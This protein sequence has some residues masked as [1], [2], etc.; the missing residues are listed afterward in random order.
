M[1]QS[2]SEDPMN[3][4]RRPRGLLVAL[5]L[6]ALA[7]GPGAT[8][9]LAQDA[10]SSQ[11][12]P[13]APDST[14]TL[15]GKVVSAMTGGPLSGARVVLDSSG[16]GAITDSTGDF[17]IPRAPAGFVD[18]VEVS[19]IGY[20][21]QSVPLKLEAGSTTRAVFSLSETVLRVEDLEVQVEAPPLRRSLAEF[22]RNRKGGQG[23][24]VTPQMIERQDPTYASDILRRVPGVTVGARVNGEAE[25]HFVHSSLN[26]YPTLY[27]N[28]H[29]WPRHNLDELSPDQILALEVY[30]GT[31]EVPSRFMGH[32]R[33]NCGV[34]VVWTRQGGAMDSVP[35]PG[36]SRP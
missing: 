18:T 2:E 3:P 11:R 20:A 29:L 35:A 33:V 21:E 12:A 8:P 36:R 34:I 24:Y 31:S 15:V 4:A 7:A 30:R 32:G 5:L 19:L 6:T 1:V 27:L 26:C 10:G 16:L 14:A 22:E 23:Y 28:G 13:S 17:R 9:A 25:I